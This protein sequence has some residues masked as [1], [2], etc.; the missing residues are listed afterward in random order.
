MFRTQWKRGISENVRW[1]MKTYEI[2]VL[3][4]CKIRWP[5]EGDMWSGKFRIINTAA[6]NGNGGIEILMEKEIGQ[7]VKGSGQEARRQLPHYP[8]TSQLLKQLLLTTLDRHIKKYRNAKVPE[9]QFQ[10]IAKNDVKKVFGGDLELA[11]MN[12]LNEAA[13]LHY[14]LTKI[15]ILKLVYDYAKANDVNIPDCL[16]ESKSAGLVKRVS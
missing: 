15:D 11:L 8:P 16:G 14:G 1:E 3:E 2:D 9:E 6:N 10:Y 4:L 12:Y 7:K 13:R 5:E